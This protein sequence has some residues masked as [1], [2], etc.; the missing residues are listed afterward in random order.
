MLFSTRPSAFVGEN[1][2]ANRWT[3]AIKNPSA[4]RTNVR[5]MSSV[6]QHLLLPARLN[7]R[8]PTGAGGANR[9]CSTLFWQTPPTPRGLRV[10]P[11]AHHIEGRVGGC[12]ASGTPMMYKYSHLSSVYGTANGALTN[13]SVE[14]NSVDENAPTPNHVF[15]AKKWTVPA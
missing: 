9:N 15:R 8:Q 1:V 12:A 7:H 3:A 4:Y 2:P 5:S 14:L 6:D 13:S 11:P 10:R